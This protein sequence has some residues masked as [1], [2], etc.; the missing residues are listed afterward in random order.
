MQKYAENFS[1]YVLKVQQI[2]HKIVTF[3]A[4]NTLDPLSIL[5]MHLI[6]NNALLWDQK[7]LYWRDSEIIKGLGLVLSSTTV[8]CA[9]FTAT[10]L[11]NSAGHLLHKINPDLSY[12]ELSYVFWEHNDSVGRGTTVPSNEFLFEFFD[13]WYLN[14]RDSLKIDNLW[15]RSEEA[16]AVLQNCVMKKWIVKPTIF[17]VLYVLCA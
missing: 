17:S 3:S 4:P 13:K 16:S 6:I 5:K 7:D 1:F 12:F 9:I 15:W 8:G 2:W 10:L 11:W 14:K